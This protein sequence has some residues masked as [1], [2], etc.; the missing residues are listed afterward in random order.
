[1]RNILIILG[2]VAIG[3]SSQA[4]E[5][6]PLKKPHIWAKLAE[7]PHDSKLWGQYLGKDLFELSSDETKNLQNWREE[8]IK[9]NNSD[10]L[11]EEKAIIQLKEPKSFTPDDFRKLCEDVTGNFIIIEDYLTLKFRSL[12]MAYQKY[13]ELYPE[14]GYS[15]SLWLTEQENKLLELLSRR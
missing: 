9:K 8:L 4:Q 1:M 5:N 14:G 11:N 10:K 3:F 6:D 13:N 12:G 15:K 2:F 7:K